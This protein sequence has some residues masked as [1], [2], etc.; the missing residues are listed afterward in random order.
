MIFFTGHAFRDPLFSHI[1]QKEADHDKR[2]TMASTVSFM[3]TMIAALMLPFW[4]KGVDLF[5]LHNSLFLLGAFSFIIGA[6]GLIMFETKRK[7]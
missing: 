4:G 2:S 1:S 3:I 7:I 5:G 6:I